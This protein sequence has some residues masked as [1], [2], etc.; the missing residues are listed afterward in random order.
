MYKLNNILLS[1]YGFIASQAPNSNIAVTGVLDMPKRIGKTFHSWGDHH[2]VEPYVSAAEIFFSGREIA[3]F[4]LLK[5]DN[6]HEAI[7][8]L[9]GLGFYSLL[10]SF[11]EL[12]PLETPYGTFQV[13]VK[14]EIK[15]D[16][17]TDGWCKIII[18]FQEPIVTI[19]TPVLPVTTDYRD[20]GI[21][22][23]SFKTL[24]AFVTSVNDNMNRPG[25]KK[26]NVSVYGKE[27]YELTKT[28]FQKIKFGLVFQGENFTEIKGNIE[29]IHKQLASEGLHD[30]NI[31]G[32]GRKIWAIDGFKVKNIKETVA[33]LSIELMVNDETSLYE[34]GFILT[35]NHGNEITD[36]QGNTITL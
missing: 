36:K 20:Y 26:Q 33:E 27:G 4:G 8:K 1:D 35:D 19:P 11:T 24:N 21:D 23:I 7:Y 18:K 9:Q 14:E 2:G 12:M 10:N 6:K 29:I 30:I 28:K 3:F 16:Y 34:E 13:Y 31:D 22:G 17:L 5:A 32:T 15:V 25:Q